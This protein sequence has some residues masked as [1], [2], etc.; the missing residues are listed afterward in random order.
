MTTAF[1]P[2]HD[3]VLLRQEKHEERTKGGLFLPEPH[4]P[5]AKD[6]QVGAES[7]RA[8]WCKAEVLAVGPG[9]W[10]DGHLIP[11]SLKAGDRV[12]AQA[13]GGVHIELDE[14]PLWI[15]PV[16]DIMGVMR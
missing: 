14:Q 8:K 5:G 7:P 15:V 12:L 11:P 3:H 10:R 2:L 6:R 1:Q 4:Y 16:T 13:F 9:V